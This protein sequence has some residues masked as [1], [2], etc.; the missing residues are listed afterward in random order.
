MVLPGAPWHRHLGIYAVTRDD[1]RGL[2]VVRKTRGPYCGL[3]DLPGGSLHDGESLTQA[4]QR[5]VREETG[6]DCR[7]TGE[8]GVHEFLAR[9]AHEGTHYTHHIAIFRIVELLGRTAEVAGEVPDLAG[10]ERNDSSGHLFLRLDEDAE[11][12]SPLA[13]RCF[14]LLG[15]RAY[16]Q[17]LALWDPVT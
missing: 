4:L 5:E 14:A 17:D 9:G 13:R 2:L 1:P 3:H 10:T 12:C 6:Y 15:G 16:P 11:T 7:V 8:L